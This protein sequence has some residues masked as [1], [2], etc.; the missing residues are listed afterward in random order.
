VFQGS[1]DGTLKAYAADSGKPVWSYDVKAPMIAPP[2]TYRAKGKQYV[3]VLTG[4][5]MGYSMNGGALIGPAI[6]KYG[7]DPLTQARRVLTFAIGGKAML[8]PR[9]QP[10]PPPADPGFVLDQAQA[11]AGMA[12]Y[13]NHCSTCH[14]SAAVGI[15]NGPDL[16]RSAVPIDQAAFTQ[17]VR[18]GALQARGMPKFGEFPEAKLEAIRH[19][20]RSRA[21]VLRGEGGKPPQAPPTLHI[22]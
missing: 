4:L 21:A 8:P 14:G 7:V 5:G 9:R 18:G 13:E 16:R 12:A 11:M 10:S 15:G 6:E 17:V 1:I 3:T 19:Y 20:L 2:I 22:R